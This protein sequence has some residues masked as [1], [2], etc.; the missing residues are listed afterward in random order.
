MDFN[1][2]KMENKKQNLIIKVIRRFFMKTNVYL[3]IA[4]RVIILFS[5]GMLM[6]Y[7]KPQLHAFLGDTVHICKSDHCHHADFIDDGYDWGAMHFWFFWMCIFLFILSL[8]NCI[9]SI[10]KIVIKN[11]DVSEWFGG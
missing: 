11:Y 3:G 7:V 8:I 9:F 4:F 2:V 5:I 10:R 1:S 6:A